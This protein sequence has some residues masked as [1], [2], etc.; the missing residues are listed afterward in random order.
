MVHTAWQ[1]VGQALSVMFVAFMNSKHRRLREESTQREESQKRKS[2]RCCCVKK[3][4][5]SAVAATVTRMARISKVI[6][7]ISCI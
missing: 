5:L 7:K 1:Y 4:R 6:D 3:L 2:L